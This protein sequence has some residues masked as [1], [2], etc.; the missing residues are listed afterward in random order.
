MV[1]SGPSGVGKTTVLRRLREQAP[2]LWVSVS[3]T[4]RRPRPG[5]RDGV[6]YRFVDDDAFDAWV[7][8]DALLEWAEYAGNRYGTPAEPVRTRLATG[9]PALLE[10][11]IAGAHQ[12]R[13]AVPEAHLVFLR[14]PSW[15]ALVQ[16]LTG[17]G[18][19]APEVVAARLDQAR[20]EM[21]AE[22]DFDAVLVNDDLDEVV[23]RLVACTKG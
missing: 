2:E 18:T 10:I 12:V 20:V 23:R 1:L 15:D 21:A 6:H 14:P 17:R 7:A 3:V 16:R 5:E 11:E 8:N 4:T 9:E 19:E 22:P 13:R